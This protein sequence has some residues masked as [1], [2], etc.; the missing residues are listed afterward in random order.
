MMM[1]IEKLEVLE[2][3]LKSNPRV[4]D[5]GFAGEVNNC[6]KYI[7]EGDKDERLSPE[8]YL[9][10]IRPDSRYL[11]NRHKPIER[12]NN[13]NNNNNNNNTDND[14]DDDSVR[15]EW[16]IMLR[17]YIRCIS[18]KSFN[19]TRTMHPKSKQVEVHMGSNTEIVIDTLFNA[20][21][22]NFER[23]QETSNERGSEFILDIVEILE[24]ELHKIGIIRAESYIITPD[25]IAS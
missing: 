5:R 13:N 20:L 23:I 14:N 11:I 8:E 16:K 15:G 3:Y 2:D 17:M 7:S 18:T 1:N 19:E 25:W 22:Q 9:N 6:I 12:L 21:L 24:Y 10:M 4:I